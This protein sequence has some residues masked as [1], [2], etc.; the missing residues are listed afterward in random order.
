MVK[1][2]PSFYEVFDIVI[3]MGS[4][5][6]VI[7]LFPQEFK[8]IIQPSS[9]HA[10]WRLAIAIMPILVIGFMGRHLLRMY[11]FHLWLFF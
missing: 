8:S 4:I 11:Y 6:A 10:R 3:Q 9:H 7:C 2:T 1:V 5:F